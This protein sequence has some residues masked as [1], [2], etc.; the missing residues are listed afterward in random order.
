M[1]HALAHPKARCSS[2][3]ELLRQRA[4]ESPDRVGYTL[5]RDGELD[6]TVSLTYARLDEQARAVAAWLQA[7]VAP[8]E[9]ALL[10][11]PPGLDFVA[12]FYG[13]LYAGVVAV[14]AYPPRPNRRDPRIDQIVLDAQAKVALTT[15]A[16]R[17]G[18]DGLLAEDPALSA[19]VWGATDDLPAELAGGWRPPA[20]GADTLAFLQYT[21]GS[22]VAPKGVMISHANVLHNAEDLYVG[23]RVEDTNVL[24]SWLP[25]FHDM[26]LMS[27]IV[28][29][30]YRGF[31]VYL[32]P[33]ASF[34][35]KPVRWL[36]AISRLRVTHSGGPNF[37]YELCARKIPAEQRASLDLS[38]WSL[39]FTSAEPIRKQTLELFAETFAPCGFRAEA[40]YPAYGLAE[41]TVKVSAK[42]VGE[43]PAYQTVQVS[44][45]EQNR[46][47]RAR[48]GEAGARTLVGCGHGELDTRIV[49]VNPETSTPCGDAEVGEIWVSSS[50]VAR[51]Y[52]NRPAETEQTFRAYLAGTREGPFLRTGDLGFLAGQELFVTGRIKELVIIRGLNHYPQDIER[53][54]QRSHPALRPDAGAVFSV[55]AQGEEQL[56]IVQELDRQH[57]SP[58]VDEIVEAIRRAVTEEHEVAPWAVALIRHGSVLKT[59]SGK[60]QRGAC[61]TAFLQGRL[62]VVGEWRAPERPAETPAAAAGRAAGAPAPNGPRSEEAITAWLIARL[63]SESGIDPDEIDLGRPFAAFGLDSARSLAVVGELEAWLGQRLSPIL[64]WNYPTIEA[65]ARQLAAPARPSSGE[66]GAP[67]RIH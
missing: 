46:V 39:A 20:V 47:V 62:N 37:A 32:M 53:T 60:I 5:L 41:S 23:T 22:T 61:R 42:R 48:E 65:L 16:V 33:P 30:V 64:L 19:L 40:F 54:A 55:E 7:R 6:D 51:G 31:A 13:C 58:R 26:G 44:A 1:S 28:E 45:L 11:Y 10:L 56:V 59:S 34:L 14:P 66:T 29:P 43:P 17:A 21:S 18:L 12:A 2:L 35:Q 57:R 9:R 15:R 50:S 24:A 63:S 27:G 67:P 4:E 25:H 38:C 3:V 52:W 8:G 49:I 36:E